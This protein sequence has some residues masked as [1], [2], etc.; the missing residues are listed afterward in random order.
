MAPTLTAPAADVQHK[1]PIWGLFIIVRLLDVPEDQLLIPA[2]FTF[3]VSPEET[4]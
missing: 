2:I 3:G 4:A 1:L